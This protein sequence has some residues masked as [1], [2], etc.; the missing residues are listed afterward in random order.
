MAYKFPIHTT[1]QR[2]E[3]IVYLKAKN[4]EMYPDFPDAV[5]ENWLKSRSIMTKIINKLTPHFQFKNKNNVG[6][7]LFSNPFLIPLL[8]DCYQVIIRYFNNEDDNLFLE[9]VYDPMDN[10]EG[11]L[12]FIKTSLNLESALTRLD[13][14]DDEWWVANAPRAE[15]KL[16]IDVEV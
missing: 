14:F 2:H 7:Y 4:G 6:I 1:K 15:G 5:V 3:G 13:R 8:E 11:L 10:E 12:L 9:V 16:V